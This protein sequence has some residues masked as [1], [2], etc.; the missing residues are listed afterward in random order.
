MVNA[1]HPKAHSA[2]VTVGDG[3]GF[4]IAVKHTN[5][6]KMRYEMRYVVT[7]AHCLPFLPPAMPAMDAEEKTY[8]KLLAPLGSKPIVWAECLFIDPVAD[9]AVLG[10]P[11]G[12]IFYDESDAYQQLVQGPA[13]K[14]GDMPP[15]VVAQGWVLSLDLE[16]VPCVV[17]HCNGPLWGPPPSPIK[18]G[19]SGS[20]ILNTI[21]TAIGVVSCSGGNDAGISTEIGPGPRLAAHLPGWLLADIYGSLARQ[22]ATR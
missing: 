2:V 7:A 9:I 3:R 21:G 15:Y 22:R 13:L 4:V 1:I 16:W 11:D 10:T 19:M 5:C 18:D 6:E 8:K 17:Q 20:P 14:I 12:Q